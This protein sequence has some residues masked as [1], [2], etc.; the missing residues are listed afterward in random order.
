MIPVPSGT[1]T[2]GVDRR[3][4]DVE[5]EVVRV[6]AVVIDL[7]VVG[8]EAGVAGGRERVAGDARDVAVDVVLRDP[9]GVAH[10]PRVAQRRAV[11]VA[12]L[13][14]GV[15]PGRVGIERGVGLRAG[16]GGG[17]RVHDRVAGAE[18]LTVPDLAVVGGERELPVVG[19]PE[20]LRAGE[21]EAVDL[22][23]VDPELAAA[24]GQ[25]VRR[26]RSRRRGRRAG[27]RASCSS[28][29]VVAAGGPTRLRAGRARVHVAL[30][31]VEDHVLGPGARALDLEVAAQARAQL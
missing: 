6:D 29:R 20:E 22:L 7:G 30:A 24:A 17:A 25:Q 11:Q 8:G 28:V 5:V 12:P 31:G 19:V 21:Q 13:D 3:I 15:V 14:D 16:L 23:G 18:S 10:R 4:V 2:S 27:R 1:A 26:R 9:H